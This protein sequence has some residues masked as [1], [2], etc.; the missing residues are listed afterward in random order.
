MDVISQCIKEH[1]EFRCVYELLGTAEYEHVGVINMIIKQSF[2]AV[3]I[4]AA[5]EFI[6]MV[7]HN[8]SYMY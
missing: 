4:R 1:G 7:S 2:Y 8:Y 5:L 3:Y 6:P